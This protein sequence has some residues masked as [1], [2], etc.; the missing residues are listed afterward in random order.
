MKK[1][2]LIF[3]IIVLVIAGVIAG[4]LWNLKTGF[5]KD[6]NAEDRGEYL[7]V[8][9]EIAKN[10]YPRD[11]CDN[12]RA[13]G[14]IRYNQNLYEYIKETGT[15]PSIQIGTFTLNNTMTY[16]EILDVI[17]KPQGRKA[18]LWVTIPEGTTLL[19]AADIVAES[20]GLCTAEEF[21]EMANNGD[22]SQYSWWNAI[23]TDGYRF[24][25]GEGYLLPDTYN[26]YNDSTVY[27]LVDRFYA[28]FDAYA[29]ENIPQEKLDALGMTLDDVIVL[30]SMVQEE[31]GNEQDAMVSSVFHNRLRDGWKL[32]SNASSYI[33]NDADN[34]YVHNWIAP[35]YGGWNNIP[36]GMAEAYDTYAVAGLPEGPISNPGRAAIEAALNPA[37]SNYYFFVTDP[38]GNYYYGVTADEHYNNCV[39]AG[40]Y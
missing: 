11:V 5:E 31:A 35:Y 17:T 6:M 36:E 33:V 25:R 1:G 8:D 39:K 26:F 13:A 40:L 27:E 24:M 15:G 22:F 38:E 12:L 34:N 2:L 21:L 20:T 7:E 28:A 3:L 19:R 14:I 18:D 30:A 29:A 16:D 4:F 23:P 32:E 10:D 37:E 9:F